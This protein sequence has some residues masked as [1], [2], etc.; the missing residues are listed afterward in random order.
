MEPSKTPDYSGST[1]GT[2][3]TKSNLL[4]ICDPLCRVTTFSKILAAVLFISLPF[5][6]A[7][8]GY[9]IAVTDST[10]SSQVPVT[11]PTKVSNSTATPEIK[12]FNEIN[13]DSIYSVIESEIPGDGRGYPVMGL[14]K[15][16]VGKEAV[17]FASVGAYREYPTE[18][19]VSPDRSKVAVSL[20]TKLDL[21]DITTGKK[22]TLF[23]PKFSIGGRIA[24]SSDSTNLAFIDAS[25]HQGSD[26]ATLYT[27]N[28]NTKE[29]TKQVESTEAYFT[30]IDAWRPDGRIVLST[31]AGKGCAQPKYA[32]FDLATKELPVRTDLDFIQ[33]SN[34]GTY[35]LSPIQTDTPDACLNVGSM[36]DGM[37]EATMH[38]RV[39]DP[40]TN[41]VL[42]EFGQDKTRIEFVSLSPK[43]D[44]VLYKVQ[45]WPT[46]EAQCIEVATGTY[47]IKHFHDGQIEAVPDIKAKLAEWG[48][49]GKIWSPDK[50]S[51]TTVTPSYSIL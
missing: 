46:T 16:E 39:Y 28:I 8:V 15:Q 29:V 41:I 43:N 35:I 4:M 48:I 45:P 30:D 6:G 36:C 3:I 18:F 42:G 7:Y 40:L 50:T 44:S 37:Y 1:T 14:Y 34:D 21:I 9:K 20:G 23:T 38:Y 19:A 27:A 31:T 5:I 11:P 33:R 22:E 25:T 24:F 51:K 26:S 32:L 49:E 12:V 13:T 17:K 2:T 47:Y 10:L